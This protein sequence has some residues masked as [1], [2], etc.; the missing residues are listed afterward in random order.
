MLATLNHPNIVPFKDHFVQSDKGLLIIVMMFCDGKFTIRNH[1]LGGD[2]ARKIEKKL[3]KT[4]LSHFSE[5]EVS[6]WFDQLCSA[7]TYLDSKGIVHRDLKPANIMLDND[8]NLRIGDLGLS[9]I[10]GTNTSIPGHYR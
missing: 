1:F 9:K 8:E 3:K 5:Y 4:K 7:L 6:K 2:L 10:L